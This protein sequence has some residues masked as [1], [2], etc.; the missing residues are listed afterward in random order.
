MYSYQNVLGSSPVQYT[1]APAFN[2]FQ[3]ERVAG[4]GVVLALDLCRARAFF[5][6]LAAALSLLLRGI[7]PIKYKGWRTAAVR[8][9]KLAAADT[10]CNVRHFL[11]L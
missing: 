7:R 9:S 10:T 3:L 8:A 6:L 2:T 5:F 1:V 11:A 4:A